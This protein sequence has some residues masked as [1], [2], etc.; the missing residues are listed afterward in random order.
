[1]RKQRQADRQRHSG[2][3]QGF[4]SLE[5]RI[6]LS[7][8]GLDEQLPPSAQESSPTVIDQPASPQAMATGDE[9]IVLA[10]EETL[11]IITPGTLPSAT[12]GQYYSVTLAATG[13]TGP[14]TWS[15]PGGTGENYVESDPGSSLPGSGVGMG[16]QADDGSFTLTLPW[17]FNFYGTDYAQVHVS[18]NGF[19]DF[20]TTHSDYSNTTQKLIDNIRIAPLWDDLR[21]DQGG[22]IS[23]DQSDPGAVRIRWEGQTY[24]GAYAV[25]FSVTLYQNGNIRFDYHRNHTGLTP[26][27]GVS[28]GDGT[29]YTLSQL[30]GSSQVVYN[31]A[32]SME[33]PAAN[34]LPEGLVLNTSTGTLYGTP[35]TTGVT[36]FPVI[37]TDS[38]YPAQQAMRE[39]TLNVVALA[40]EMNITSN[41]RTIV[42]G[43]T[44]PTVDKGTDF[45]TVD[46]NDGQV[47]QVFTIENRG[48]A[49]LS[50]NAVTLLGSGDFAVTQQPQ[51]S[52]APGAT[53]TFVVTFN[54]SSAG[55]KTATVSI[56]NND[57][58]ENPYTFLIQGRDLA[59]G[60]ATPASLPP[61]VIGQEYSVFLEGAG[62]TAPYTW[63]FPASNDGYA[64][65]EPETPLPG[66]GTAMGWHADDASYTLVLPWAF[67][68]Y[69]TDYTQVQVSTNGF[70]DFASFNSDFS[71]TT[72]ELIDNIRI[73]PLWDDLRTDNGGDIYVDTQNPDAV[74]I[75]WQGQTYAGARPVDFSA[76]LYRNGAI[77]FDYHI[78]HTN[79]TPTIGISSGD[80]TEYLLSQRN[81]AVQIAPHDR[82]L[83]A[84]PV[85]EP[86]PNGLELDPVTGEIHGTPTEQGV[87]LFTLIL[88]D[89]GSPASMVMQ[90]FNLE[91]TH[92]AL[93]LPE[94][95]ILGNGQPIV[96]G[97]TSP[98]SGDGTDFGA[99]DV[100]SGL[101]TRA[102][103][104]Q[105]TG[106]GVLN[107]SGISL[108]GSSDF[109]VT[110]L[111]DAVVDPGNSTTFVIVF[112]PSQTGLKN[113]IVSLSNN[114]GDEHPYTFQI[115]GTGV[116]TPVPEIEVQGNGQTILDGDTS[117]ALADGTQFGDVDVAGGFVTRIFTVRNQGSATLNLG[118]VLIVG[119]SAFAVA[120]Q[121]DAQV[122]PG[123]STTFRIA[124]DPASEGLKTATISLANNDS[125]EDP[126]NFSIQGRGVVLPEIAIR[127]NGQEIV[128][129]DITPSVADGTNFGTVGTTGSPVTRSFTIQNQGSGSL[130]LG[131]VT[132][133]GSSDFTVAQQPLSSVNPGGNTTF[134]ITFAP[135]STGL[136]SAI[137]SLAS[138]DGDE[139]PYTFQIQGQGENLP[140]TIAT[141]ANLPSAT[142][143]SSYSVFLQAVGGQAPYTWS[144]AGAVGDSYVESD[145][146]NTLPASGQAMGWQADDGSYQ[147]NLPWAFNFYGTD[148]SSVWVST[149]GFLDFASSHSDYS[150]TTSELI[151]SARIAALWDDLRTD[152]GGDI[153]VDTSQPDRVRVRWQG[154]TYSGANHVDFSVTLYRDGNIR[155]DYHSS[156]SG[157]T[158]TVGISSGD[159][160][161]YTL[162]PR[163]GV[164]QINAGAATLF[165]RPGGQP[166]P[167]GLALN[168]STGEIHGTPTQEGVQVFTV[169][170][171]DAANP[172]AQVS[173]EF[174][175]AVTNVRPQL[176]V[177]GNGQAILDGDTSPVPED[178]TDFG[179]IDANG[180]FAA[181]LYT[182]VNQGQADLIIGSVGVT[183]SSDFAVSRQP[184]AIVRPGESTAFVITFDPSRTGVQTATVIIDSNANGSVPYTFR[185]QG[186]HLPLAVT[187]PAIL[188]DAPVGNAYSTFLTTVGGIGPY[189]WAF[190]TASTADYLES[191]P[192]N[193]PSVSGQ[194]MGWQADDA[195]YHLSLPW[196]FNF[197]GTDYTSVKVSTNG[198]LDFVSSNSDFSNSTSELIGNVRVAP[199][200]DDLRTDQGG[201]IYVNTS[202]PDAV[203]IRWQGQTYSGA[204]PVDFSVTLYRDGAIRFDYHTTTTSLTP[205][206]GISSGDGSHYT[207][208]HRDGASQVVSGTATL[209]TRPAA[210]PL[211]I[212]LTL[213]THTGE[214]HGRPAAEGP[215]TFTVLV[216][217]SG[218]PTEVVSREFTLHVTPPSPDIQV[219]GNGQSIADG[220]TT[221]APGTGT[222]FG[223]IAVNGGI[224][225][226][227]FTIENRG[228]APLTL[229]AVTVLGSNQFTVTQAPAGT[230]SPG[231]STTM[232]V[233]FNPSSSGLKTATISIASNDGDEDPYT[234]VVQGTG[235]LDTGAEIAVLGNGYAI[236]D[237]DTSPW[238]G[239]GSDYGNLTSG[240]SVTHV[241]TI[242]N[243]GSEPLI[244]GQITVAGGSGFTVTQQPQA[245]VDPGQSTTF[246]LRFNPTT[247]GAQT[248]T[249]S[250]ASNDIDEDPFTFQVQGYLSPA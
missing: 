65:T 195:M 241:F 14:I 103:T 101:S 201:D 145:P 76:T 128:D 55:L 39:F 38:S 238:A 89:S 193:S 179:R 34:P 43:D 80:G 23:V 197:Y 113:A 28:S 47:A 245:V 181:H 235:I 249:V 182:V 118:S 46:I 156:S 57:S 4:E 194:A 109:A 178:A 188:P 93:E 219:L 174:T 37:V 171:T 68:F 82:S 150:N 12:L 217:D 25:D 110:Q 233:S 52:V 165:Q 185:V 66:S 169:L 232:V 45:G 44:L 125:N 221:P 134:A 170:A 168:A 184:A 206:V 218:N 203:H 198:F 177:L 30:N 117:P 129:G 186:E 229:G 108:S 148:Y 226:H 53:T 88:T 199:L 10:A 240:Q 213:D 173:R 97:D 151:G 242:E 17:A 214:I 162:S 147:L 157:L 127:G 51:A 121:P 94:I 31:T 107:L 105:N 18:T 130:S 63:S 248:A 124:F 223:S 158:P 187:A 42:S 141:P 111:P 79:L 41:G 212:G 132:L 227:L 71:N 99:I 95:Q 136:K 58:D 152:Q 5:Q 120:Q 78:L 160:T 211:P 234:F 140:L 153:Y 192:G 32:L 36:V 119:S 6:L 74:R 114:D 189:T 56:A 70:L 149:N 15:F 138:N 144:F 20:A 72:Q 231:G 155:F 67:N 222:D 104:V 126:Y 92:Q 146:G 180:A 220:D 237:S 27:V 176:E 77:R 205:T 60:M 246:A 159:G 247:P 228:S 91:V 2:R 69:G 224:A 137:V 196:A 9:A 24:S 19:L 200:W 209:F 216:T 244:L 143:G 102:F 64:E 122:A 33:R 236:N 133:S 21:T 54:P 84:I 11:Q 210:D 106:T 62:G 207:L 112:N 131:T 1:M 172:S 100:S 50:L 16:W 116:A 86:L 243:Q 81:E 163:D 183:G 13:G 35:T 73:A 49:A 8:T 208:S 139:N 191:E 59:L 75:R 40:P 3:M 190:P 22:D 161:H 85:V 164:S 7:G 142:V 175:L 230:V 215:A 83:F 204:R 154:Q 167:D 166:L 61:A 135:G 239:D 29:R 115:Q 123:A 250:I 87:T 96:N 225:S 48:G 98:S 26:T 90:E 202:D